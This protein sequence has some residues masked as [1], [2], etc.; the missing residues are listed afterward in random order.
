MSTGVPAPSKVTQRKPLGEVNRMDS[1]HQGNAKEPLRAKSS[2]PVGKAPVGTK[3]HS[4]SQLSHRSRLQLQDK[5]QRKPKVVPPVG[6]EQVCE[7]VFV[8]D[9]KK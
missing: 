6:K 3:P 2:V 5:E 7:T 9:A 8:A 1:R 4:H